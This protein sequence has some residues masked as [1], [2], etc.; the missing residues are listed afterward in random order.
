MAA[1]NEFSLFRA[2]LNF[3]DSTDVDI[4]KDKIEQ[5]GMG[6]SKVAIRYNESVDTTKFIENLAK[7]ISKSNEVE[8]IDDSEIGTYYK[9][10]IETDSGDKEISIVRDDET[11]RKNPYIEFDIPGT[12]TSKQLNIRHLLVAFFLSVDYRV[13]SLYDRHIYRAGADMLE[14]LL[15]V[16]LIVLTVI[17]SPM[18]WFIY[19]CYLSEKDPTGRAIAISTMISLYGVAFASGFGIYHLIVYVAGV[20]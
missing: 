7:A 11:S 2:I 5:I 20:L 4:S 14:L 6:Y 17:I 13:Q 10:T 18:L 8:Q 1:A 9:T 12:E 15:I 19:D 3:V 16:S